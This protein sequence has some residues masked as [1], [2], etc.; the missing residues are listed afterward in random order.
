MKY[1]SKKRKL[2]KGEFQRENEMYVF[3]I[4]VGGKRRSLYSMSLPELRKKE[5][6]LMNSVERGI[7]IDLKNTTLNDLAE[8]YIRDK[9]KTVQITTYQTMEFMYRRYIKDTL[10]KQV[11]GK[12]KRSTV[13]QH[14][15]N[16]ISGDHKISISTLARLDC[17]VKPLFERAVNDDIKN[18][19][20]FLLGTG[21]RV[22][23]A[24]GLTWDD[25]DF[26]KNIISINHAAAYVKLDGHYRHIIKRTKSVAGDRDIP[27]LSEV[28]KALLDQKWRQEVLDVRQPVVDGYTGFVFTTGLAGIWVAIGIEISPNH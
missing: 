9:K 4:V 11:L 22:G 12:I 10:G 18:L 7:D 3:R 25:I 20:V 6:E 19:I 17:I 13:K 26:D 16:L 15:L 1:D 8:E 27:M 21:C 2:L 23:E 5:R 14:Y 24:I 28:K